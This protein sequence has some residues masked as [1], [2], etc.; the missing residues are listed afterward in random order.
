MREVRFPYLEP[1]TQLSDVIYV[2]T[3]YTVHLMISHFLGELPRHNGP[4]K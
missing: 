3:E 2:L 1:S 4:Q